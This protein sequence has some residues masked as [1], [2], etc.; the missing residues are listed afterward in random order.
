MQL[1]AACVLA[2]GCSSLALA[3]AVLE[4]HIDGA[5]AFRLSRLEEEAQAEAWGRDIEADRRAQQL[6][7][8]LLAAGHFLR[9]LQAT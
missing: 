3:L 2:S 4:K 8:E 5:G 6:R 9:L 7:E 1:A